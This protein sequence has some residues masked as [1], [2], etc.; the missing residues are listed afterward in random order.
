MAKKR[1]AFV[2]VGVPGAGDIIE[3]AL[4]RHRDAL[5][6]LGVKALAKS[7]DESFLAAVEILRDH[8][9]W[10]FHRSEVE[11]KWAAVYRRALK[12][13]GTVVFSQPLLATATPEQ[14]DLFL[15]GLAGF[16]VH[17]VV[18]DAPGADL[19]DVLARWGAAVRKP[20]RLHLVELDGKGPKAAWKAF[21]RVAGFGTASLGLDDVPEPVA[22]REL[23]SLDDARREIERLTRRNDCLEHRLADVDRKRRRLKRRLAA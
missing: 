21:G 19:E 9:A 23:R 4:V 20:E 12:G 13:N 7:T 3:T 1:K 22:V 2:H 17:V 15:D 14:I 6:E 8:K 5:A 10:G 16:Q 18:T 11:G